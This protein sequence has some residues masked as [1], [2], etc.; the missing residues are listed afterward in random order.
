M[1]SNQYI[2]QVKLLLE[3]LPALKEQDTFALKGGTAIN[4]FIRNL[5]RLSVDIDLTYVKRS[6][7]TQAIKE[8][9]SGLD[10]LSAAIL[11]RNKHN[12]IKQLK[13]KE[14]IVHKI[15]VSNKKAQIKIEPNFN[16]RGM[17][18]PIEE[19]NIVK[20]IEDQFEF[21]VRNIPVLS[22]A[23]LY[24]GKICAALSRQHPR[25]FFDIYILLKNEGIT[26]RIRQ[27]FVVYLCC[28][29]RPMHELLDPNKIDLKSIYE[30]EF[31]N[32]TE[33]TVP[34]ALLLEARDELIQTIQKDLSSDEKAFLISVKKGSPD[35]SL[36]PFDD[37][38]EFPALKWKL[39]NINKMDKSKHKIML[40]K[41]S[42]VLNKT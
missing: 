33:K 7:R 25:D 2:D 8:I 23:E 27:A 10:M 1:Y 12:R 9:E 13:T 16:L 3:C 34:L 31:V 24:A 39:I 11:N 22:Q 17:L 18:Y 6:P 15:V 20:T 30:G 28:S 41:L 32:M 38:S 29:P 26:E 40:D 5:P 37:L 19:I 14:G 35:F 42:R 4:F 21:S 36:L